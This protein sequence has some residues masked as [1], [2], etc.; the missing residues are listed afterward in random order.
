MRIV[1]AHQGDSDPAPKGQLVSW[2]C[3][4]GVLRMWHVF[5]SVASH[6]ADVV[7]PVSGDVDVSANLDFIPGLGALLRKGVGFL[8]GGS[9]LA[10][11]GAFV[12]AVANLAFTKNVNTRADVKM[13]SIRVLACGAAIASASSIVGWA[14]GLLNG[15]F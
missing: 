15:V 10:T 5:L 8:I 9:L 7:V 13:W 2:A 12:V 11:V 3:V 6:L 1:V 4:N 14:T